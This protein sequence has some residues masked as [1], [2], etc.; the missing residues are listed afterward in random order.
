M[1]LQHLVIEMSLV[2]RMARILDDTP[3][4]QHGS[5]HESGSHTWKIHLDLTA[6]KS[7]CRHGF[8][9]MVGSTSAPVY[10]AIIY[11]WWEKYSDL[12]PE[13]KGL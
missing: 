7:L 5:S 9:D 10:N 13:Y 3:Y 8:W 1:T 2:S 4:H 6:A 11:K 12:D